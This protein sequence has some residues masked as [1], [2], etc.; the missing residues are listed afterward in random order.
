M[1]NINK[2]ELIHQGYSDAYYGKDKSDS[3]TDEEL[4]WYLE[5]R[6]LFWKEFNVDVMQELNGR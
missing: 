5:G 4:E 2:Q 6:D 1:N 3:Y